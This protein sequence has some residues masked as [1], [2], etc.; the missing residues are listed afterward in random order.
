METL[1]L[2]NINML[3]KEQYD[4]LENPAPDELYAVSSSGFGKPSG[5]YIDLSLGASG[6][7]YEAPADG[8]FYASKTTTAAGQ[9][10][11]FTIADMQQESISHVSGNWVGGFVPVKK[12]GKCRI[13]YTAGGATKYFRFIFDEGEI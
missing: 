13:E 3:T 1:G 7:S 12:G 6:S 9:W 8:W 5:K 10:L 4:G 11:I 2:K